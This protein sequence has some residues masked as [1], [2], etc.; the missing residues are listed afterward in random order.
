[1]HIKVRNQKVQEFKIK[2]QVGIVIIKVVK[3]LILSVADSRE[4]GQLIQ[5]NGTMVILIYYLGMNGN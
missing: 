2:L 3:E 4:L 1:M 5:Q